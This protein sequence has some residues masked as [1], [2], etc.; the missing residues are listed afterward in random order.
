MG[1]HMLKSELDDGKSGLDILD[2][3]NVFSTELRTKIL[4]WLINEANYRASDSLSLLVARLTLMIEQPLLDTDLKEILDPVRGRLGR[5]H[6]IT[7]WILEALLVPMLERGVI[8]PGQVAAQWLEDLTTQWLSGLKGEHLSFRFI[9]DGAF[10]DELAILFG[11]LEE[12]E[13]ESLVAELQRVFAKSARVIRVPLATQVS[14]TSYSR[15]HQ[16]NVWIYSLVMRMKVFAAASVEERLSSLLEDCSG[17]MNRLSPSYRDAL[18]N[19]ELIKYS[20]GD[21]EQ[22]CYHRLIQVI[23]EAVKEE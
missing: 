10:T 4:C 17:L 14:W 12:R 1:L 22:L 13:Q 18:G 5:L 8:K 3:L 20:M 21:P 19:E 6:H 23:N 16:A 11:F 9:S 15:A 7:P 2:E